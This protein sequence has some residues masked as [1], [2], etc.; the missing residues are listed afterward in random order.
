MKKTIFLIIG[1]M[2]SI[3]S[4]AEILSE[5]SAYKVNFENNKE[6]F[7][8]ASSVKPKDVI[9]YRMVFKNTESEKNNIEF[10]GIIKKDIVQYI[11]DGTTIKE[12]QKINFSVDNGLNWSEKPFYIK[13]NKKVFYSLDEYSNIKWIVEKLKK[14]EKVEL[15]YRVKVK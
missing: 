5:I 9:E 15:K 14:D 10:S 1:L 7:S 8:S 3:A 11:V 4:N 12:N 13:D 2:F 6:T